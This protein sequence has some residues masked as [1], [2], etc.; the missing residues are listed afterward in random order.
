MASS[1]TN[2]GAAEE[3][4]PEPG[5]LTSAPSST[6]AAAASYDPR[7]FQAP[8]PDDRGGA[9]GGGEPTK[10]KKL[11]GGAK[12]KGK[13]KGGAK[14]KDDDT[15]RCGNCDAPDAKSKCMRCCVEYYC[16]REC[17]KVSATMAPAGAHSSLMLTIMLALMPSDAP[18]AARGE[19]RQR[20][21]E[22]L[23]DGSAW[24]NDTFLSH[25]HIP[26]T[27]AVAHPP[28]ALEVRRAQEGL[29]RLRPRR[30]RPRTAEAALQGG[31]RGGQVHDL[32]RAAAQANHPAVRAFVLHGVRGGAAGEGRVGQLSPL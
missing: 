32:P 19:A 17:Q 22:A 12:G 10:A 9:G 31:V 7:E 26:G 11:H 16:G 3:P 18:M 1:P 21:H 6:F 4:E 2:A 30:R 27:P 8:H 28:G 20:H 14:A 24:R 29:P 23:R 25:Q 5:P 15:H 13:G